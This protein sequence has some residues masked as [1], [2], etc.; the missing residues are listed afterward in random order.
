MVSVF[1]FAQNL[2]F[3]TNNM[4][5]SQKF[6]YVT[7]CSVYKCVSCAL[8]LCSARLL[9]MRSTVSEGTQE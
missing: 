6:Y 7:E 1:I 2:F 9:Q 4:N 5:K 3:L 8:Q